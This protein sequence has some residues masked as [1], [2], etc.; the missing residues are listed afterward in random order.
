MTRRR[1]ELMGQSI[2]PRWP[3]HVALPAEDVQGSR[4]IAAVVGLASAQ[5]RLGCR[6]YVYR[7]LLNLAL[8]LE[9]PTTEDGGAFATRRQLLAN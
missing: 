9:T 5:R 2:D 8:A 7:R 6:P 1:G 3:H 4:T